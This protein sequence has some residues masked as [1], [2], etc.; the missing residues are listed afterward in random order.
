MFTFNKDYDD[1]SQVDPFLP[2]FTARLEALQAD[3]K[4]PYNDSFKGHVPGIEGPSEDSAIYMLQGLVDRNRD[5]ARLEAL[6]GAGYE[7]L[8]TLEAMTRYAHIVLYP[9]NRMN[10]SW[11]EFADARLVP[12]PSGEP[13]GV[14]P[15]GKRTHGALVMGRGV[16]VKR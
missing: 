10:G 9:K 14:I 7:R 2:A 13:K 5:A 4:Y 16:L 11:S 6:L 8:E 15:K 1:F 3:G 12:Y